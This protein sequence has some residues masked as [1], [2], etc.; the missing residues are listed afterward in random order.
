MSN[1]DKA[2]L[3]LSKALIAAGRRLA[4]RRAC[5]PFFATCFYSTANFAVTAAGGRS[6]QDPGVLVCRFI[7]IYEVG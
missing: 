3:T 2:A 1:F 7:R 6:F 5:F 4:V